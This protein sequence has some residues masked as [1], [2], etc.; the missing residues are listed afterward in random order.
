V[1]SDSRFEDVTYIGAGSN[2]TI[3]S[4]VD[5]NLGRRVA[6]KLSSDDAMLGAAGRE[7]LAELGI[8]SGFAALLEGARQGQSRYSLLREARLLAK[9]A[10]P[11]VISVLD[12]GRTED[13]AVTL[14]MP[15]LSGGSLDQR[16]P[17]ARWQDVLELALQIGNGLVA[18]HD[19]GILHRDL[20][21]NNVLFDAHGWPQIADLGLACQLD[22]QDAMGEWVGTGRYMS[23]EA[24]EQRFRD[25]RDDLY[26]Y[27][28]VMFELFYGSSPFPT[29]EARLATQVAP[30]RHPNR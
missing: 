16:A 17:I 7:Q 30:T 25:Q 2:A 28:L 14:V 1:F 24:I 8:E 5:R 15:L 21:P 29:L 27:S 26:A 11:N 13:G 9:V 22:D 18:I 4:A 20:K 3:F 12:V 10:H 6:L 23:P 19:A